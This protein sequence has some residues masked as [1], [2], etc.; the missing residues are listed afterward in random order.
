MLLSISSKAIQSLQ[1]EM[2]RLREQ[3]EGCLWRDE[4][5]HPITA[6]PLAQEDLL[7]PQHSSTPHHRFTQYQEGE[8]RLEGEGEEEEETE[9]ED[10]D[11]EEMIRK[12]ANPRTRSF[13]VPHLREKL[14]ITS[15]S[16]YTQPTS[17]PQSSRQI[18]H[19][20]VADWRRSTRSRRKGEG[21]TK[22]VTYRG[23][24]TGQQYSTAVSGGH[25]EVDK[26]ESQSHTSTDYLSKDT[27]RNPTRG[28][29]G[30][31]TPPTIPNL[32]LDTVLFARVSAVPRKRIAQA[33]QSTGAQVLR[34]KL[35]V[36]YYSTPM[37]KATPTYSQPDLLSMDGERG[38]KRQLGHALLVDRH[39]L[40]SS[41]SQAIK[42][43]RH[44]RAVSRRMAHS[45]STSLH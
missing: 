23:P 36:L 11:E 5:S 28:L 16:D 30:V 44:M 26:K 7:Q 29:Q 17:K 41:L 12:K 31:G 42:A 13:S 38:R 10:G 39:S 37:S 15:E 33:F 14:D 3:L 4:S 34:H 9:V 27:N 40:S 18:P 45:L 25:D 24:Y 1:A 22:P 19:S 6:P 32:I 2:S 8:R 20:S 43:A 21:G 35:V